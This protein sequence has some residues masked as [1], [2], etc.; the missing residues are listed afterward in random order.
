[1]RSIRTQCS[2]R[3]ARR[4]AAE[5]PQ[6]TQKAAAGATMV[7]QRG[8]FMIVKYMD[9]TVNQASFLSDFGMEKK[10]YS[11]SELW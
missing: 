5:K 3:W 7:R 4:K 9:F 2:P 11:L 1:M 8:Q 6:F 10:I